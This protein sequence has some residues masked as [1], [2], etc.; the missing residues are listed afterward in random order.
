MT[1]EHDKIQRK[2]LRPGVRFDSGKDIVTG[3]QTRLNL[4]GTIPDKIFD[5]DQGHV[6]IEADVFGDTA[7]WKPPK[8]LPNS[9]L[10]NW[11]KREGS[12]TPAR[13]KIN[14]LFSQPISARAPTLS[15]SVEFLDELESHFHIPPEFFRTLH[16][17]LPLA[18]QF[19]SKE[20]KSGARLNGLF[21]RNQSAW[22]MEY[23][24]LQFHN[25]ENKST[26]CICFGLSLIEIHKMLAYLISSHR[27]GAFHLLLPILLVDET[28]EA[29]SAFIQC[30]REAI[31]HM[32]EETNLDMFL[33]APDLRNKK[34]RQVDMQLVSKRL[35]SFS[36]SIAT[37]VCSAKA[38]QR[39]IALLEKMCTECVS[40]PRMSKR[41]RQSAIPLQF[42][43]RLRYLSEVALS[44]EEEGTFLQISIQSQ[45]QAVRNLIAQ[46]EFHVQQKLSENST[47]MARLTQRNSINMRVIAAVTLLFL[48]GTFTATMFST[49]FF[50]FKPDS[51]KGRLVSRW[52]WLY[53]TIAFLLTL[54]VLAAWLFIIHQTKRKLSLRT[55]EKEE[56]EKLI[57][58]G[59]KVKSGQ[60]RVNQRFDYD[61]EDARILLE[62]LSKPTETSP[63]QEVP[64]EG[65]STSMSG[66][67]LLYNE[68]PGL[69]SSGKLPASPSNA[70]PIFNINLQDPLSEEE[71]E[72]KL[73]DI[74]QK[75]QEAILQMRERR[76]SNEA[77]ALLRGEERRQMGKYP[78]VGEMG[79]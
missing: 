14:I 35:T 3:T 4:P 38:Q 79:R 24:L 2:L 70:E 47:E 28:V 51:A 45:V 30:R 49:S 23:V 19:E 42:I 62:Y 9:E 12:N 29:S 20:T 21:M 17:S 78:Y 41:G 54:L 64:V 52:I 43:S 36:T 25:P 44:I 69:S 22:L 40:H 77:T 63:S 56:L 76:K 46:S 72:R 71:M 68:Q 27:S 57:D 31:E 37:L 61:A 65:P 60:G 16:R 5:L 18:S 55:R 11:I 67:P 32:Q 34:A 58:E 66:S 53:W 39:F 1:L 7:F 73:G 75:E 26:T 59:S 48:P 8:N 15:V 33:E 74:R 50:D 10:S 13:N 6:S